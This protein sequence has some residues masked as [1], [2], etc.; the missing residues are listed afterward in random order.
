M[1]PPPRVGRPW[2]PLR[3]HC[4]ICGYPA[5]ASCP[6]APVKGGGGG[7][8]HRLGKGWGAPPN[9]LLIFHP[10]PAAVRNDRN[11]KKKEVK[12]EVTAESYELSPELEE[13]VQKVSRAHQETFPSLCQLGKYTTVS[14]RGGGTGGGGG[15]PQPPSDP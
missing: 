10:H 9:P 4:A 1:P 3:L 2:H 11:K 5:H 8:K 6:R 7:R 14:T 15:N 13:L 12:E